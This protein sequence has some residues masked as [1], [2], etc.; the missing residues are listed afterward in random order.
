VENE[1]QTFTLSYYEG[2]LHR[3]SEI[4]RFITFQEGKANH[5]LPQLIMRHDIDMDLES[6]LRMSSLETGLG[7]TATYFFMVRNPLY[8]VFSSSGSEQVRQI[9]ANGHHFGASY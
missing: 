9:L 2:F 8:N 6:A 1:R 5:T 3:L 4:Y 7:L